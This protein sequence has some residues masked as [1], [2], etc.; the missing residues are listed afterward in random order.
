MTLRLLIY[1]R[2]T[3]QW[4]EP[5]G[6]GQKREIARLWEVT[7]FD[8]AV[9]VDSLHVSYPTKIMG[10]E[11]GSAQCT[12]NLDQL[13]YVLGIS[14]YAFTGLRDVAKGWVELDALCGDIGSDYN[15]CQPMVMKNPFKGNPSVKGTD[16][17]DLYSKENVYLTDGGKVQMIGFFPITKAWT[18]T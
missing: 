5:K 4:H 16:N 9:H 3:K 11:S 12:T 6:D 14:S 1:I 17:E 7:P 2:R 13:N 10:T 8:I 18:H 15:N